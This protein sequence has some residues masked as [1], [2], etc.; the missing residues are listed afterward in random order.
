MQSGEASCFAQGR[1]QTAHKGKIVQGLS[2]D[3]T[4]P[5]KQRYRDLCSDMMG[6][7]LEPQL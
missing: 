1:E 2:P 7:V 6:I 4:G 3:E 5:A